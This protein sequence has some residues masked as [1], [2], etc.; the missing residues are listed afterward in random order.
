[1]KKNEHPHDHY[2]R[3]E[4]IIDIITAALLIAAL[5]GLIIAQVIDISR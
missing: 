5:W 2:E 4:R 1:M 3:R